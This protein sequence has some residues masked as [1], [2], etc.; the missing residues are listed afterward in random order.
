[1]C[2]HRAAATVRL[3]QTSPDLL[4]LPVAWFEKRHLGDVVS[5]FGAIDKIQ[6]TLTTSFM[7]AVLDGQVMLI[8]LVLMFLYSPSLAG[9]SLGAMAL[10]GMAQSPSW[11]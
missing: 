2:P 4:R 9:I 1:M 6:R 10:Y 5:R 3:E 8:T 11:T 7:E